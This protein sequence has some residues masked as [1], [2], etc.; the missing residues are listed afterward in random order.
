MVVLVFRRGSFQP[1]SVPNWLLG[2]HRGLNL[3]ERQDVVHR[4]GAVA[5]GVERDVEE[6]ERLERGGDLV[7]G[8][9]RERA[10]QL[11]PGDLDAGE[12]AVV[13]DADLAE[14]ERVQGLLGALH[15]A[16]V[17]AGDRAAVLDAAGEAGPGG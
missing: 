1:G 10:G 3:G 14:A 2:E 15:L 8:L 4:A 12:V 11:G 16:E 6:A 13:T 7:E 9:D 17:L 5:L